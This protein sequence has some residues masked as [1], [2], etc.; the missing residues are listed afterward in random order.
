MPNNTVP[1]V[2]DRLAAGLSAAC[3]LHCALAP[4]AL[5]ALPVLAGSVLADEGFHLLML[6]LILPSS[7]VALALGCRRHKDAGVLVAGV[8]GLAVLV[9]TAVLGHDL[10]G[11]LGEKLFTFA[12]AAVL[13]AGHLRNYRLCRRN[14]CDH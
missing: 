14:A 6:W 11:E 3:A 10:L 12:G 13:C 9:F 4:I 7:T 2:L 1:L 8:V 5:V